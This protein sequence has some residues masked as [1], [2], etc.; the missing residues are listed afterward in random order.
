MITAA[1]VALALV[2]YAIVLNGFLFGTKRLQIDA[3]L[4]VAWILLLVSIWYL[5]DWRF[6]LGA[7]G[8]SFALAFLV[9]P[10]ARWN[11]VKILKRSF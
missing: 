11:A 9:R 4:F 2:V 1:F 10:I 5:Q 6:A 7:L 3:A 8:G